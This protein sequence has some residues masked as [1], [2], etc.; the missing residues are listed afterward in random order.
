MPKYAKGSPEM[1]AFME[2]VR[3][4][5][6]G[7]K[8]TGFMGNLLSSGTKMLKNELLNKAPLPGFIKDPLS[9]LADKGIDM[10]V[11]KTGLGMRKKKGAALG[12]P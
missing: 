1:K 7:K 3:S 6:K 10:A 9:N 5:K 4:K 11:K 2:M 12:M 8:G